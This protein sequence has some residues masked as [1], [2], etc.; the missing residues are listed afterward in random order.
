MSQLTKPVWA[1]GMYLG[2]H[3]FQAQA[4]YFEDSLHFVAQSLWSDGYGFAA[5]QV[6]ADQL[7]N[8][9]LLLRQAK[10]LFEDGLAFDISGS[11][12]D[13]PPRSFAALFS[14]G[15]EH[16][17]IYLAIPADVPD[18]R[19]N[20]L[21]GEIGMS[22]YKAV[23]KQLAD[24]T[25][26]RDERKV[27]LGQKNL[28]LLAEG[29]LT[30]GLV[31]LPLVRIVRDRAGR[32]EADPSFVPPCLQIAA[33]GCLSAMLSRLTGILEQKSLEFS[34]EQDQSQGG[35]QAGLSVRQVSQFWFL[36]A[37][38]SSISSL[39]HYLR[40]GNVHPRDLFREML[41]LGGALCT[42]VT[43]VQPTSLPQ[44]DHKALGTCFYALDAHIREHIEIII[45]SGCIAISLDRAS[46]SIYH[47]EI[48]DERC[49]G[50]SR[51]ILE[52]C[53]NLGEADLIDRV[54]RLVKFC[55]AKFVT[56]LVKRLLPGMV[57]GHLP[58]PPSE[59]ETRV[60]CQYFVVSRF[61]P[62]WEH[63]VQ[64][65][66]VGVYIPSEIPLIA[67]RLLVLLNR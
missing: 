37:V 1:E 40:S 23:D 36:H 54:P 43:R 45:R 24:K 62:C 33:S 35:F 32:F 25:T 15:A 28:S 59:I 29:E 8:G 3:H 41:R 39:T 66:Q 56:E 65:R 58:V 9:S 7:R 27:K 67:I 21:G 19:N 22:R 46:D 44:Y 42:F 26:G 5:L 63:I 12:G 60:D 16:L 34:L 55:S 57:L 18:G 48:K 47:G 4:R 2:P 20:S 49:V 13:L 31:S 52:V 50:P 6:D 53:A 11:D 10:G 61:G 17:T 64:S 51:W 14:P 30:E 38:N